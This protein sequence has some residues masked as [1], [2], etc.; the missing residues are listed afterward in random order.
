MR[1]GFGFMVLSPSRCPSVIHHP[2]T[3]AGPPLLSRRGLAYLA[4]HLT[5]LR[6]YRNTGGFMTPERGVSA[7]RR[8]GGS[9][10]SCINMWVQHA[11]F[12]TI[13]RTTPSA[14]IKASGLPP[15]LHKEGSF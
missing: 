11:P 2:V 7:L 13:Q 1:H 10:R 9:L 12:S 14:P 8:R 4:P 3:E 15:L 6:A 5:R